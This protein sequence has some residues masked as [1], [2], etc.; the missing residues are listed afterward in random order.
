MPSSDTPAAN[1]R[2]LVKLRSANALRFAASGVNL[3]PLYEDIQPA[4]RGFG[5]DAAPQWFIAEL[6]GGAASPWDLAHARVADQLG[7]TESDVIFAEPDIIHTIFQD[8]NEVPPGQAFAASEDCTPNAQDAANG[9]AVGP[10]GVFAWHLGPGF[11]ELDAARTAVPFNTPRPTRIAHIDTGYFP[12]HVTVPRN[13]NHTLERSFVDGENPNSAVNPGHPQLLLD[14]HTHGTGTLSILAGGNVPPFNIVLGGAPD[15]E[16]VPLR[17]AD[18]VVLL[19]TS[20]LA[21]AIVY[22]T[23][24]GCDVITLSM[25]GL[26]SDA[27]AEA[28]DAAYEA[29][30]CICAAA[31]NHTG[32]LPPKVLVYPARYPRVIAVTGVMANLNPYAG[33]TGNALEGSFG[34]DS[35]MKD[36]IAAFT[37]NIPWARF[38]C[39]DVVR[40]NGEGTSAAT[41]QVAA[42]VALWFEKNKAVLPRNFQRIEAVRKALFEK[43]DKK[44]DAKHFGNGI[45]KA[46]L[47]LAVPPV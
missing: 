5:I 42:A 35:V 25:G 34:P 12:T 20:A 24:N 30:L 33:L 29:G 16:I 1:D 8:G 10:A 41:P 38:G 26:P 9:K 45:L 27:W 36:A 28:V 47:A 7:V 15:A 21:R 3:A 11:S 43:A 18:S 37:P 13:I 32:A 39:A 31:G 14:N 6:P 19:R 22:A 40:L 17:V 46:N 44:S 4:A 2:V 23:Q